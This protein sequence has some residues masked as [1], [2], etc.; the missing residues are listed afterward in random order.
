MWHG[1]QT[2]S[3]VLGVKMPM[4]GEAKNIIGMVGK[5]IQSGKKTLQ[6]NNALRN[7]KDKL[8]QCKV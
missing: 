3:T 7:V 6:K 1:L 8:E 4:A 5:A 2:A